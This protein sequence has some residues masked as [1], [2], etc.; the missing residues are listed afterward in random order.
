[1]DLE[2]IILKHWESKGGLEAFRNR[3]LSH[4]NLV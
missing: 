2:N 3:V 1:M 4:L